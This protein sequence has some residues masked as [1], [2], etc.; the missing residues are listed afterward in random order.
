[1]AQPM[2]TAAKLAAALCFAVVGWVLADYFALTMPDA[3]SVGPIRPGAAVLGL[4]IGWRV[5]GPSVGKG[6]VEAAGSGIKTSVVLG[7]FALLFLSL[8]EMLEKSVKQLYSGALDAILDVFVTMAQRAEGLLS[9][10]VIGTMLIGGIV[11]G[12]LAESASRRWR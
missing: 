6:Y 3:S 9:L 4:I 2:P 7:F 12:L 8:K 5:M 10:G 1:M 11:G